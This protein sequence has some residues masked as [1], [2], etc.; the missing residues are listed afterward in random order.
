MKL[1]SK[2]IFHI[3]F[4]SLE[5]LLPKAM[6]SD[7]S[8]HVLFLLMRQGVQESEV[9][10]SWS[11][12]EGCSP[13]NHLYFKGLEPTELLD[14]SLLFHALFTVLM[15]ANNNKRVLVI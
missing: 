11:G 7:P 4:G 6:P 13:R 10:S 1:F 15:V 8:L 12:N 3:L 14:I 9:F 2:L 5:L